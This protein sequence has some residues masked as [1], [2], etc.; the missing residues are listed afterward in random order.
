[1]A[2]SGVRGF[3]HLV[4]ATVALLALGGCGLFGSGNHSVNDS[5]PVADQASA[6]AAEPTTDEPAPDPTTEAPEPTTKPT[7]K[8]TKAKKKPA[9][10]A[11]TEDPFWEQLPACAH[12]DKTRPVS[13]SKVKAALKDASGRI[14]WTHEAPQLKL[15][16]TLVKGVSYM[17]SGWQSNIHNCDGGTGIM[18]VMP[19]T[20]SFINQRFGLDYDASDYRQNARVGANYLAYLTRHAGDLYFGGKYDLSPSRCKTTT[21]WCLLNVVISGYNA[22]QG[23][24]EEDGATR[25]VPNP[26]YVSTV[27]ALMTRCKCDQY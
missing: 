16:Y 8:K 6:P 19:D 11:P 10:T 9:S 3:R 13:K 1:M 24:I 26:Q 7:P 22:G 4:V 23:S 2:K 20:V 12:K 27:R 18:Q 14:Y 5:H 21:S 15:N 25:S 17:E